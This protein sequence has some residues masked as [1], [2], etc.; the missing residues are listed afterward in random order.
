V[1]ITL[2]RGKQYIQMG[3]STLLIMKFILSL[4]LIK[5]V[6]VGHSWPSTSWSPLSHAISSFM[7]FLCRRSYFRINGNLCHI[8]KICYKCSTWNIYNLYI[9]YTLLGFTISLAVSS[10]FMVLHWVHNPR[11]VND[12]PCIAYPMTMSL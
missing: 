10:T 4:I 2:S 7:Q 11:K 12:S 5:N 8:H 6:E 1:T 3:S 9:K